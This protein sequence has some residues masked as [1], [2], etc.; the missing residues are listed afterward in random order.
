MVTPHNKKKSD[1]EKR[2]SVS[3]SFSTK[4]QKLYKTHKKHMVLLLPV[5]VMLALLAAVAQ[6]GFSMISLIFAGIFLA[7]VV[8]FMLSS[9][10]G[11]LPRIVSIL[12]ALLFVVALFQLMRE[13]R[14]NVDQLIMQDVAH[15]QEIF[16]KIENDCGIVDFEH[17]YNYIDFLTVEKFVGSEIGAM[18]LLYSQNWQGPYVKDN[19]TMQ[20]QQYA[21]VKT[22]FGHYIVPGN[23]VKLSSGK[24][25]GKDIV[26]T[27]ETDMEKLL[28][29]TKD[30]Q[31]SAG[32]LVAKIE[33]GA[34]KLKQS[35]HV[36]GTRMYDIG[37]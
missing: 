1:T 9:R 35:L 19:P 30:L 22:K 31:S 21:I 13:M 6:Q 4:F 11:W 27:S 15:L 10:F 3:S 20:Q 24:V 23:G 14:T 37:F 18:N 12:F 5:F 34:N 26:I 16:T 33:I 25:M 28:A 36:V 7:G 8:L 32:S 2:N 17:E 29:T